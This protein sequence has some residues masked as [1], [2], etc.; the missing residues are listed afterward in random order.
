MGNATP[1]VSDKFRVEKQTR[2]FQCEGHCIPRPLEV[3]FDARATVLLHYQ[4]EVQAAK[5]ANEAVRAAR[6]EAIACYEE[7]WADPEEI[8]CRADKTGGTGHDTGCGTGHGASASRVV[9][10]THARRVL[11]VDNTDEEHGNEEDDSLLREDGLPPPD[12]GARSQPLKRSDRLVSRG[13]KGAQSQTDCSQHLEDIQVNVP[14]GPDLE[15]RTPIGRVALQEI[16]SDLRTRDFMVGGEGASASGI[17]RRQHVWVGDMAAYYP[18]DMQREETCAEREAL[19]ED[20]EERRLARIEWA[21]KVGYLAEL[22]RMRRLE[23][24]SAGDIIE[25]VLGED[26]ASQ[27]WGGGHVLPDP[28]ISSLPCAEHSTVSNHA[29]SSQSL[30]TRGDA[31][32]PPPL[33]S[34][35]M[36]GGAP[37]SHTPLTSDTRGGSGTIEYESD[38]VC[39]VVVRLMAPEGAE[40]VYGWSREQDDADDDAVGLE[41]D[42]GDNIGAVGGGPSSSVQEEAEDEVLVADM[43]RGDEKEVGGQGLQVEPETDLHTG[44]DTQGVETDLLERAGMEDPL[45]VT[46]SG[47]HGCSGVGEAS[48]VAYAFASPIYSR[49]RE[50]AA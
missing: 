46:P 45:T 13:S 12:V 21:G 4:E 7:E 41:A 43:R 24:I 14:D 6:D 22:E 47:R 49:S 40:M 35:P 31:G 48:A 26:V 39:D 42:E 15:Q 10:A 33:A 23:T 36:S 30:T 17:G 18:S 20:E 9:L 1:G 38:V 19:I 37:T 25:A 32:T 29:T 8:A 50:P 27:P 2:R 5:R 44:V 3:V 16:P 34:P 11:G 28:P